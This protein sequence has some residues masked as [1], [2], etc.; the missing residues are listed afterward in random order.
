[1]VVRKGAC[2]TSTPVGS[3]TGAKSLSVQKI[4]KLLYLQSRTLLLLVAELVLSPCKRGPQAAGTDG[5]KTV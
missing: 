2:A 5:V 1:M 4:A 3:D